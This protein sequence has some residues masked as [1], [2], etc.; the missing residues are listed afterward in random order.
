VIDRSCALTR[1]ACV[2]FSLYYSYITVLRIGSRGWSM[3]WLLACTIVEFK[4]VASCNSV[5]LLPAMWY[6]F[7][8]NFRELYAESINSRANQYP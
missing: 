2:L 8:F 7:S 6:M 1:T 4:F 3:P 5:M